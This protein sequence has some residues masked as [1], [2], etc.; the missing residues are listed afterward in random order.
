MQATAADELVCWQGEGLK[1]IALTS[2]AISE[3]HLRVVNLDDAVVGDGHAVGG[4]PEIVAHLPRSCHGALGVDDPCL[5]I[6]AGDASLKVF[7]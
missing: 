4:A 3:A 7:R 1:A 2:M 5:V 6:E